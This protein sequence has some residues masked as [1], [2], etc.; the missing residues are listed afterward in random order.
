[1]LARVEELVI[2]DAKVVA[3]TLTS[4]YLRDAI[5]HRRFD[6][7]ILDEASMA[8]VPALWMAAGLATANVIAVGDFRQLP[9]IVQSNEEPALR[10]HLRTPVPKPGRRG[11]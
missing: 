4:A 7:V 1:M 11:G 9:P 2:E 3:T 6:T 8:P 5:Q 10:N